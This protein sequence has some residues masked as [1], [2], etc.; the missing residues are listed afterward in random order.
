MDSA[1]IPEGVQ[2]CSFRRFIIWIAILHVPVLIG[3]VGAI[4]CWGLALNQTNMNNNFPF[5]L[6]IAADLGVIALGGGAFFTGFLRYIIKID[7]LKNIVNYAV[8][9][10]VIC[11]AS[12]LGILA[13]DIGQPLRGWF[14]F[15]H[16]NVHSMLTE[17][18]FCIS[19]Y[20]MVLCIEY[21]PLVLENRQ[22]YKYAFPHSFAHH[23]HEAMPTIAA[24]GVFLSCFHQ[25]SLGGV[26]G[27]LYGRPFAYR[28]GFLV[29]PWTFFLFILSAMA[30]GPTFTI[31]ITKIT[32][33]FSGKKL[34]KNATIDILAKIAGGL[35]A[36]YMVLKIMD[37]L[38]WFNLVKKAGAP[39]SSF[40]ANQP[41]GYWV[42]ATELGLG[43]L[44]AII[45][46]IR[47]LRQNQPLL[48][49]A[50][51]SNCTAIVM[52]RWIMTVQSL[53]VP[54]MSF[55]KFVSYHPNWVEW[56]TTL[57]PV[58]AGAIVIMISYRY[59]P[60]FPQERELN[61]YPL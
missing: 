28:E 58:W 18:A 17:V 6:W 7:D 37:T 49:L 16:A 22:I 40:Y 60:I 2:R 20:F 9:I 38:G 48:I 53:A 31:L 3:V 14:I 34:V 10:G 26:P 57:L 13:I 23:L 32:E 8:V 46:I 1:L 12:A 43:V 30:C 42:L 25:G 19:C 35:T 39:V 50:C 27:V 59:L 47:P 54:V 15:W 36:L 56:A 33:L 45:L 24:V 41:Y 4:L 29:W 52:N 51:V 61:P 44:A 5:G 11:Y 21:L 55:D